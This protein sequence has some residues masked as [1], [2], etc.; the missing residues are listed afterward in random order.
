[1]ADRSLCHLADGMEMVHSSTTIH[2]IHSTIDRSGLGGGVARVEVFTLVS[3][4]VSES[5]DPWS[6]LPETV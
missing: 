1:M 3:V 2:S 5:P 4:E 6:S